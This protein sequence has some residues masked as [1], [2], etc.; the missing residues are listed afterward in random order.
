MF[1]LCMSKVTP[2][3]GTIYSVSRLSYRFLYMAQNI[4]VL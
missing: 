4:C 3:Y 1:F 2:I